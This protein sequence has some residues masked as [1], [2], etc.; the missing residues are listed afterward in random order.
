[1]MEFKLAKLTK[2]TGEPVTLSSDPEG[3]LI[4]LDPDRGIKYV[5]KIPLGDM[6]PTEAASY[7]NRIKEQIGDF[8]GEGNI[9]YIPTRRGEDEAEIYELHPQ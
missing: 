1:M 7:M 3:E 5:M 9:L 4:Q 6:P 8:F 2:M